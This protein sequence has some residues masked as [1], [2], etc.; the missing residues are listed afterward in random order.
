V[1]GLDKELAYELKKNNSSIFTKNED[2]G[3]V[4]KDVPLT[5]IAAVL[6]K[7]KK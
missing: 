5:G 1:E 2:P 4:P 3:V 6:S 7:Y